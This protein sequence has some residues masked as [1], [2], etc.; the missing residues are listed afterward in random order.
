MIALGMP[1]ILL[2]HNTVLKIIC[3][4]TPHL[5]E[6][7]PGAG[8]EGVDFESLQGTVT[9]RPGGTPFWGR[10]ARTGCGSVTQGKVIQ[11]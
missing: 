10:P 5:I 11:T 2:K 1:Q 7:E 4:Q 9:C 6:M 8:L 3:L